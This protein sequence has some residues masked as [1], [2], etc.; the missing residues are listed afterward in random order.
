MVS[1]LTITKNKRPV[2]RE[3]LFSVLIPSWN[4]LPYLELC[5]NSIRKNSHFSHQ[6]IVHVNEGNDGTLDWIRSREDI[7]YTYS[8]CNI[9]I[10]YAL[11]IARSLADTDYIVYMNDDM[12]ACPDWDLG[13]AGEVRKLGHPWFFLSATAIEPFSSGNNCVIVKDYGTAIENFREEALLKEVATLE[14]V[15]WQ[16][17][18][19][20]PNIVHKDC[21][22]LVGGYSTE[23]SPGMYSDPDFSMKLWMAGVR[24]FKGVSG[25]RVYHFGSKSVGRILKNKGYYTFIQKWGVTPGTFTK[26]LLRSGA[27]F[28]EDPESGPGLQSA[29]LRWKNTFKRIG[30]ALRKTGST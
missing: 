20:P 19:W 9:G 22:D 13:L 4:N 30:A 12:Y 24:Y 8:P 29:G 11:N 26:Q 21:W 10:C 5:I 2:N 3:A 17:S 14:K 1:G 23:F 15:D 27:P 25:S 18:T 16:G 7:D 28:G 6:I